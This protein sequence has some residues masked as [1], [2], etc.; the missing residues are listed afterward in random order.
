MIQTRYSPLPSFLTDGID[1]AVA[2]VGSRRAR[3]GH[4]EIVTRDNRTIIV[5]ELG[6]DRYGCHCKT[7]AICAT[8]GTWGLT[9][10]ECQSKQEVAVAN[11]PELVDLL[12]RPLM[13]LIGRNALVVKIKFD[14]AEGYRPR[15]SLIGSTEMGMLR[16]A[17]RPGI[18]V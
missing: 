3:R 17:D 2:E 18:K 6:Y 13:N 14:G 11:Q 4:V 12:C 5:I 16:E 10:S 9:E 15:P 8:T 1:I 7:E